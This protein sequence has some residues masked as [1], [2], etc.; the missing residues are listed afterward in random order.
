MVIIGGGIIGVMTGWQL[1]Q[2][3]VRAVVVEKGRVAGE[4]T[5]RNWGWIRQQGRHASEIPIM[6][7]ANRLWRAMAK[8]T[9][10]DIGL[11]QAGVTYLA[12]DAA[13]MA[14]YETWMNSAAAHDIDTR[15]LSGAEVA[16]ALPGLSRSYPGAM[17]TPSDLRAEPWVA[18]S[19]LARAAVRD[20][21]VIVENCAV[22]GLDMAAG[23][24]AGVVTEAGPIAAPSV[25]LAG[26][27]WSALFLRRHGVALPQLSVRA[28]VL[29]TEPLSQ[30]FE[31]AAADHKISW[32]P[33]MDGGFTVAPKSYPELFVGPD[34]FRALP[35][36]AGQ[37]KA[38]PLGVK[39]RPAAPSGY[40]DAWGTPRRWAD[41]AESPFER[42]RILNPTPNRRKIAE[43][44][45]QFADRFP[46]LGPVK[47]RTSWA[48]MI[49]TMPDVLPVVDHVG[50]IP[51]LTLATGMSGHGFGIGPAIGRIVAD[52]VMGAA[53]GHDMRSFRFARF[54]DGSPIRPGPGP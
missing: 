27:A 1:V 42:M 54:S 52:L 40:P 26:G 11:R 38:D 20:G 13:E 36:Y 34:A 22:R 37:L 18:I 47:M 43:I 53:P 49:D 17:Q 7:E 15:L 21:L 39:L 10:E 28:N 19:A 9:N 35:A 45:G 8:Q 16:Q 5:S 51:G 2:K 33:R 30:P 29:V 14:R 25:V 44:L 4:Q 41:D 3:G 48:G 46:G 24:V 6:A 50:P 31:T 12:K 32:R 23:R